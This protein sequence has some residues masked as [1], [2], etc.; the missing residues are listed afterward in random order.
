MKHGNRT[1]L[2]LAAASLLWLAGVATAWAEGEAGGTK[3]AASTCLSGMK[4]TAG[5]EGSQEMYPGRSCIDCH[6]Q[7]EGPK[8]LVAGTVYRE[9]GE[10][11]DC[12]GRDGVVV[13]LTDAKGKVIR[14][15]TNK[16]GNFTLG[17]RGNSIAFPFAAK[18]LFQGREAEMVTPQS[19]GNCATCHTAKGENGAPGR[20]IAP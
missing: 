18:V 6:A 11:D 5:D 20:I 1:A 10:S 9:L 7:G 8:F 4:W 12:Y 17:A 13:Q 14:M 2:I 16:A 15:T 3:V 19:T